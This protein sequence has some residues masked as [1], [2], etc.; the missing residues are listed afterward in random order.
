ML[1]FFHALN[2]HIIEIQYVAWALGFAAS[3][4][5]LNGGLPTTMF[6]KVSRSY[7]LTLRESS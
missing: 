4:T 7:F 2:G 5:F 3:G 6:L 1:N